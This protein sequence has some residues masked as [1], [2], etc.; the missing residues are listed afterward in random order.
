[1]QTKITINKQTTKKYILFFLFFG[2]EMDWPWSYLS[3]YKMK[4]QNSRSSKF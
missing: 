1:M 2:L 3:P 4:N